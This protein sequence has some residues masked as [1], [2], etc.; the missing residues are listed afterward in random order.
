ME[1][2]WVSQSQMMWISDPDPVDSQ[3]MEN[4]T[5]NFRFKDSRESFSSPNPKSTPPIIQSVTSCKSEKSHKQKASK[6]FV[7]RK[8]DFS[9]SSYP[10]SQESSLGIVKEYNLSD[11]SNELCDEND[12][13]NEK[14]L[15]YSSKVRQT[16]CHLEFDVHIDDILNKKMSELSLSQSSG[17]FGCVHNYENETLLYN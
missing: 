12:E 10:V 1:K 9:G 17:I 4:S 5:P 14:S 6:S 16:Y 15:E 13:N 11:K 2:S 3:V 7:R 8:L